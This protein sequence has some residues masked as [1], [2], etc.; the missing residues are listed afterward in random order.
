MS[1]NERKRTYFYR[2]MSFNVRW[3]TCDDGMMSA[4]VRWGTCDDK[5]LLFDI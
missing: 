1:P 4:Y 5:K 2:I 3:G